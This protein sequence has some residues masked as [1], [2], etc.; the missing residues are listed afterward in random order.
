M[1]DSYQEKNNYYI[2]LSKI[3]HKNYIHKVLASDG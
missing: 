1:A 3:F 2:H